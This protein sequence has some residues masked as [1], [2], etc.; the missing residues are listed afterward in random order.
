MRLLRGAAPGITAEEFALIQETAVAEISRGA[1]PTAT[2]IERIARGLAAVP[3]VPGPEVRGR[4]RERALEERRSALASAMAGDAPE[5]G[6]AA[7]RRRET[8]ERRRT[9]ETEELADAIA[10]S[11]FSAAARDQIRDAMTAAI[12]RATNGGRAPRPA[13]R[14][15]PPTLEPEG[16]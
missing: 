13:G 8:E 12:Q 1:R 3:A 14:R 5:A 16:Y 2:D 10:I 9:R 15:F 6:V 11:E 4:A 7:A